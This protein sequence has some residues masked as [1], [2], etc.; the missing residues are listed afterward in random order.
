MAKY[1]LNSELTKNIRENIKNGI[2][3]KYACKICG[4]S[5][6]TFYNWYN[7]GKKADE[8]YSKSFMMRL[9]MQK[10]KLLSIMLI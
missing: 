4:I 5:K 9:K 2:P 1:K 7:K 3:F 10:L 8:V 6:S